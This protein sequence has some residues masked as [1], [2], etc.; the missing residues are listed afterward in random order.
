M[1]KK[2]L[3]LLVAT[4]LSTVILGPPELT[5]APNIKRKHKDA[6]K[7]GSVALSGIRYENLTRLD[8][9]RQVRRNGQRRLTFSDEPQR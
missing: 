7:A 4:T 9:Q 5:P 2:L 1:H 3:L 8:R 6:K